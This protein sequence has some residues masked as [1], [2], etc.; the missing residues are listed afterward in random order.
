MA[1]DTQPHEMLACGVLTKWSSEKENFFCWNFIPYYLDI[2]IFIYLKKK[3]QTLA[4]MTFE[5]TIL[6]RGIEGLGL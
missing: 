1:N 3:E 5:G 4:Y 6:T 2:Y